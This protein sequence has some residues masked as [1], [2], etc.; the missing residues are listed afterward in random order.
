MPHIRRSYNSNLS[1]D[2]LCVIKPKSITTNKC[3]G[4]RC[5]GE[6][7]IHLDRFSL[8][9]IF[10]GVSKQSQ[11]MTWNVTGRNTTW[12]IDRG[13]GDTQVHARNWRTGNTES[14]LCPAVA[15]GNEVNARR[16][17]FRCSHS[18]FSYLMLLHSAAV[19][20]S[21]RSY[22][23]AQSRCPETPPTSSWKEAFYGHEA[24]ASQAMQQ[25][26]W[27]ESSSLIL[28]QGEKIHVFMGRHN[29]C[30]QGLSWES[31]QTWLG[32]IR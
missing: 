8:I 9:N 23:H 18:P 6:P 2:L 19:S 13:L 14:L 26:R 20:I 27:S 4:Y 11:E 1:V 30:N 29:Q 21:T 24:E 31:R 10:T 22:T 17:A 16:K 3:C 15:K 7:G 12:W 25:L 32:S 28:W 5:A